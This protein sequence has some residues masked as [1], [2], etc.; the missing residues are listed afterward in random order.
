VAAE[1]A[2]R[3]DDVRQH[4]RGAIVADTPRYTV[5]CS[6]SWLA[7]TLDVSPSL[8]RARPGGEGRTSRARAAPCE[9]SEY[10]GTTAD[11]P[12]RRELAGGKE[13][14]GRLEYYHAPRVRDEHEQLLRR[15]DHVEARAAPLAREP[16][17]VVCSVLCLFAPLCYFIYMLPR[18]RGP[19][20]AVA[21]MTRAQRLSVCVPCHACERAAAA[22]RSRALACVA[23]LLRRGLR[24]L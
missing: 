19:T 17:P 7:H 11:R 16:Q 9:Y 1:H 14:P 21:A 2:H 13:Q 20:R 4:R 12:E 24:R 5:P 18:N 22:R 6:A 15:I 10:P 23:V 3:R 8:A